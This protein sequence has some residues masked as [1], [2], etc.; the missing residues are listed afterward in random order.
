MKILGTGLL[1]LVGS[2][3][4]ELLGNT[5]EFEASETDITDREEI[6]DRIKSSDASIVLHLA[7]KADV[8][9]CEKDKELEENGDAWKVNVSG[10]KNIAE[11][12]DKTG[13]KL[14]YVS[15]DF[16][17]DGTSKIPY[18]EEDSPNPLNWYAK[19]KYEGEKIVQGLSTPW[20]IVRLAYPYRA[21]YER[22]DFF[23]AM[24]NKL[25][26]KESIEAVEDHIITPTFIDD[27]A[28]ALGG[29]INLDA[30]GIFHVVGDQS[31]SPYDA[32]SL[33]AKEFNQD[34]SLII[35]T[36]REEYFKGRALRPLYLGLKNDKIEK[37]GL[38]MKSFEE[39]LIE[40]K[41]Q[42]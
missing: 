4:F 20:I 11:A 18:S 15:T 5:Y 19:T 7:A 40:I 34:Q 16:V 25:E 24:L 2:R 23:R 41:K 10:T 26:K 8:D 35:K 32:A 36:S 39:G 38:T 30:S 9:G 28:F 1:G 3:I 21:R 22:H 6:T 31:L 12:C 14:I 33:I 27:I 17:F 13:K 42:L 37:L 29:L